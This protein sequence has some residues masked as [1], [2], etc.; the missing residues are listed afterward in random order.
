L[1]ASAAE[2][3]LQIE[4]HVASSA[5]MVAVHEGL[6]EAEKKQHQEAMERLVATTARHRDEAQE[7]KAR[8]DA[9]QVRMQPVQKFP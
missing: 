5:V 7:W 1:Q 8:H 6:L 2:S 3:A 9:N 4:Q